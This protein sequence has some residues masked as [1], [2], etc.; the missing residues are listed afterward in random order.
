[1]GETIVTP[2]GKRL[3]VIEPFGGLF[4]HVPFTPADPK[5]PRCANCGG[6]RKPRREHNPLNFRCGRCG[7]V[8]HTSCWERALTPAERH[9]FFD[10]DETTWAAI[11]LR[12]RS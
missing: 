5:I 3:T 12:C 8:I 2:N 7:I 4:E 6:R 9:N 11:C 10:N 1:M